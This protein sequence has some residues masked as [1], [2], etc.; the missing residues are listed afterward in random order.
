LRFKLILLHPLTQFKALVEQHVDELAEIASAEHGKNVFECKQSIA[1]GNETVEYACCLPQLIQGRN[2][3]V[4]SGVTCQDSKE[5][6]GVVAAIV[7]FNFPFMV[8]MWTIPISIGMGNTVVLK[9]S[10]KVGACVR[11]F[12]FLRASPSLP[13][14]QS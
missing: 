5:P 7:P 4:S 10:E 1:K 11:L 13:V 6:L 3:Q 8:P 12:G 9:P 2:L 14:S